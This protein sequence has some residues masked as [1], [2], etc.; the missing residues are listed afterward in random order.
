MKIGD[1]NVADQAEFTPNS[2]FVNLVRTRLGLERLEAIYSIAFA[3]S[4]TTFLASPNTIMV[5]SM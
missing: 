3:M 4:S 2:P 5:L 1:V